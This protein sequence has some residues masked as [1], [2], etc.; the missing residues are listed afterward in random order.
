MEISEIVEIS[1]F[2]GRDP[3]YVIAGG[4]NTSIKDEHVMY[5]KASG[6]QLGMIDASGFV[7]LDREVLK[8]MYEKE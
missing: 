1:R 4:G 7:A 2:Y 3:A 6:F 5:V 8:V